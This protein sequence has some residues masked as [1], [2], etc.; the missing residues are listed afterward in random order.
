MGPGSA[1]PDRPAMIR[2][3]SRRNMHDRHNVVD[4]DYNEIWTLYIIY[5]LTAYIQMTFD[6]ER[7]HIDRQS[8]QH[9]RL[10]EQHD[11]QAEE[12]HRRSPEQY[13]HSCMGEIVRVNVSFTMSENVWSHHNEPLYKII[14]H[15]THWVGEYFIYSVRDTVYT[16]DFHAADEV[17]RV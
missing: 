17:F 14:S 7:G 12:N 15:N 11:R 8:E 13:M 10:S 3:D 4:S 16:C 5:I 9:D 2:I 1:W 6:R